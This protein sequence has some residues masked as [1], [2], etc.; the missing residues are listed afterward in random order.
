MQVKRI[1]DDIK[2]Q[3]EVEALCNDVGLLT[4]IITRIGDDCLLVAQEASFTLDA[5]CSNHIMAV[6]FIFSGSLLGHI[7]RVASKGDIV[8]YR[9]F[10]VSIEFNIL[11]CNTE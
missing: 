11:E 10:E 9:F 2:C 4:S 3:S 6:H 8:K 1:A 7:G 5:I